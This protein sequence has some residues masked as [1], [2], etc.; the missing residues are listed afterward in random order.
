MNLELRQFTESFY[1]YG[2]ALSAVTNV[3]E[4][5]YMAWISMLDKESWPVAGGFQ[6]ARTDT[7]FRVFRKAYKELYDLLPTL[8]YA[9]C[10][11]YSMMF[12]DAVMPFNSEYQD[13]YLKEN[14]EAVV[15]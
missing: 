6:E 2:K 15:F 5:E 1:N 7:A 8:P 12:K 4:P 11:I 3:K 10:K 9:K 14:P 13:R